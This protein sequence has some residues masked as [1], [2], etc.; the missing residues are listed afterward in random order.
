MG[1]HIGSDLALE[2]L[3]QVLFLGGLVLR[4]RLLLNG[5]KPWA[6]LFVGLSSRIDQLRPRLDLFAL[7]FWLQQFFFRLS[8]LCLILHGRSKWLL[9]LQ[10]VLL[11]DVARV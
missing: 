2:I 8:G 9:P 10:V 7:I 11:L 4:L 6:F 1:H 5:Q 3:L